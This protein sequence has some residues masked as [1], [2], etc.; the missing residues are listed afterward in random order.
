MDKK[1]LVAAD[2]GDFKNYESA[3]GNLRVPYVLSLDPRDAADCT[4]LLLP[5]GADVDPS[6]FGEENCGSR[7]IRKD[8]DEAQ[9]AMLELFHREGKP[10]L[11]ICRGCQLINVFFG[12]SLYQDL[13]RAEW[14][15]RLVAGT[16]N[17]HR[18]HAEPA[19]L[20]ERLYGREIIVNSSHHQ[21]CKRIADGFRV[22]ML[23]TDGVVEAIEAAEKK[24]IGVQWHPER[25]CFERLRPEV[26]DGRLLL[27]Y[28]LSE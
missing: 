19:S 21:G 24:I 10:I 16:E 20:M 17:Y 27:E 22:T 14:H 23:S 3:L 12:G 5:G 25:T 13:E 18:A 28:F 9:F 11:G 8:L 7:G 15:A 2:A 26:A 4:H 1:V 6:Y